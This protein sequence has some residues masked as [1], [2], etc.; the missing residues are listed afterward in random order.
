[1]I[2]S[3]TTVDTMGMD[4]GIVS[5]TIAPLLKSCFTMCKL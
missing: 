5:V 4:V 3:N 1:M 2:M